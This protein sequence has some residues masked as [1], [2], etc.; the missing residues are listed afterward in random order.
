M[1]RTIELGIT[2][3]LIVQEP[4]P[5]GL[6]LTPEVGSEEKVLL[7]RNQMPDHAEVG[8]EMDV[9]I[10]RDSE[11]RLIATRTAPFIQLGEVA[12]LKVVQV[13]S[14]GAF[15]DWGLMKDLFLPFKEGSDVS[16]VISLSVRSKVNTSASPTVMLTISSS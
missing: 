4:V 10:Y 14:I 8:D 16:T 9:F 2:Q 7:P 3:K 1:S 15:L 5:M 12:S 6:Y 11:D 13:T